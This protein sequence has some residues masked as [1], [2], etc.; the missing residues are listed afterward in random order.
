MHEVAVVGHEAGAEEGGRARQTQT[1]SQLGD[2]RLEAEAANLDVDEDDCALGAV[3]AGHDVL[4]ASGRGG[5][6]PGR[7]RQALHGRARGVH[8]VARHLEINRA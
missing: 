1:V 3:Q 4:G 2:L 7:W 6:G 5:R 8:E